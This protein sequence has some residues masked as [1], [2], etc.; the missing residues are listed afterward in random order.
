MFAGRSFNTFVAKLSWVLG[1]FKLPKLETKENKR[2]TSI[3]E[4]V[5]SI[6]KA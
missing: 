1:E 6:L 2:K 5:M 3:I 4:K